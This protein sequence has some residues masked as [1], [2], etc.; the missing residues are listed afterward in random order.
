MSYPINIYWEDR[1]N[2]IVP[3]NTKY[4]TPKIC[5]E[6]NKHESN[7]ATTMEC[8]EWNA[9]KKQPWHVDHGAG[10]PINMHWEI[11]PRQD[12]RIEIL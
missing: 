12:R 6:N 3:D 7:N 5:Q 10:Y 11:R 2:V 1:H 4:W 8:M 9:W